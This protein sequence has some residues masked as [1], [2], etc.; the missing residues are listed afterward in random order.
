MRLLVVVIY[1]FT[2]TYYKRG[3]GILIGHFGNEEVASTL[4]KYKYIMSK[5]HYLDTSI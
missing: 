3:D 4:S 5:R 2:Y 1:A